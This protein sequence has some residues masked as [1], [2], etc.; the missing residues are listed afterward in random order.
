MYY[1]SI[2]QDSY[3][4]LWIGTLVGLN[5]YDGISFQIYYQDDN[6][7]ETISSS[8]IREIFED[9]YGITLDRNGLRI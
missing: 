7:P 9:S 8:N 4:Y 5:K 2:F 3:G 1:Q 6:D